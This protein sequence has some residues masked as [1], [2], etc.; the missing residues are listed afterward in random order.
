MTQILLRAFTLVALLLATASAALAEKRVALVIGNSDYVKSVRLKNPANDASR[1]AAKL[2][3]IGFDKVT[4]KLDLAQAELRRTL[5]QFSRDAAGADIALIY[6]A[7]HGIEVDGTNYIIPTDAK[8]SH[9]DDVEF[10]AI[11]LSKLMSSLNRAGTLKL[12]IL[13]ACRNN[14][15]KHNMSGTGS[16]R[17][18]G[19]GLARVNPA[20][21]D[22]LVA[23]AA[24]EGTV[25]SDGEGENS[26]YAD[27][28]I[29]HI[30]TPGIDVR[31]LFGRIRD[32]VLKSTG[33][34]QEPFTYGSLG[35]K[36]I[37]LKPPLPGAATATASLSEANTTAAAPKVETSVEGI[38][39]NSIKDSGEPS[40]LAE[41][42]SR[43]PEGTFSG[44][45]KIQLKALKSKLALATPAKARPAGAYK[46]VPVDVIN[47]VEAPNRLKKLLAALAVAADTQ[48]LATVQSHVGKKFF[49]DGDHG[50][51][52]QASL[53]PAQNF[54][55]ALSLDP[56]NI[57]ADAL[58]SLWNA[59]KVLLR[60]DTASRYKRGS[61]IVCLPGKAKLRNEA[62][63]EKLAQKFG[64]DP[65]YGMMFSLGAPTVVRSS[66]KSDA[67]I[68]GTVIDE[69]VFVRHE[70]RT[71]PDVEW[72]P[73]RL[74][75]GIKGW[76]RKDR[77]RTFQG[78]QLCF[79][80]D[81][82]ENWKIVGYNAGG[83]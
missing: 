50:G 27:A 39:W 60:A 49:W 38:F 40:M 36:S 28:L 58:P 6:F 62:A 42:V 41:Y 57:R 44:L 33:R 2:K 51:G 53:S 46:P 26:P 12:V 65:W 5:G 52:F 34:R 74:A 17:A 66:P 80:T 14:P 70:L 71:D 67:N 79:A 72:E 61:N 22:T 24:R 37:Y 47:P 45:A 20:G 48:D 19:R 77:V 73:L 69:A 16:T 76:A 63:A 56:K 21:S 13:D 9:V 83:D 8:L 68:V 31:L 75:N 25:A 4:M 7:G 15:F 30:A 1:L 35:G 78:N 11:E 54:A 23:Y 29:K 32:D 81:K 64:T 43:F 3:D 18:I 82:N 10:E 55:N 59:F